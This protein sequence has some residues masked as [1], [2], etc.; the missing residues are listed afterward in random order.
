MFGVHW[1]HNCSRYGV[2]QECDVGDNVCVEPLGL[3]F[4]GKMCNAHDLAGV[5]EKNKV[6]SHEGRES[7][8][9]KNKTSVKSQDKWNC[10]LS[11][12]LFLRLK[13]RSV[14]CKNEFMS[15]HVLQSAPSRREAPSHPSLQA[16]IGTFL[17]QECCEKILRRKM[18]KYMDL[19]SWNSALGA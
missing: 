3:A 5:T 1:T 7:K 4:R 16:F 10:H 2:P 13:S 18:G 15:L 9:K 11:P 12:E 8:N 17:L 19:L 6:E 14:C